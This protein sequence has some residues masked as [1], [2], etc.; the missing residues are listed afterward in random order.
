MLKLNQNDMLVPMII[1]LFFIIKYYDKLVAYINIYNIKNL[2]I[3]YIIIF[4]A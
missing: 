4:I 3:E 1:I 2:K